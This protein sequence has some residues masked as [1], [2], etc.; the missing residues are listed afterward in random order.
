MLSG[1][2]F[3][4]FSQIIFFIIATGPAAEGAMKG[5]DGAWS[6]LC[7]VACNVMCMAVVHLVVGGQEEGDETDAI[8]VAHNSDES[9]VDLKALTIGKI[10]KIM[11]G[12]EEP[13]TKYKG[14][15]I[16]LI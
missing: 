2:C 9:Y 12:I 3:G 5:V 11:T 15:F 10:Q 8:N 16:F 1:V 4:L 14:V 6:V 13:M 7:A